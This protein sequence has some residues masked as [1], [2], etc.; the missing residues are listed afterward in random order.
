MNIQLLYQHKKKD[1][2]TQKDTIK[3]QNDTYVK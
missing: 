2:M 3:R 1:K